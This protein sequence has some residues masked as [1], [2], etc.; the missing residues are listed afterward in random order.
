V[1]I[2]H[3]SRQNILILTISAAYLSAVT[4]GGAIAVHPAAM[5]HRQPSISTRKTPYA[6]PP[7]DVKAARKASLT[8]QSLRARA[9]T[10]QK[11][12]ARTGW[13]A[14]GGIERRHFWLTHPMDAFWRRHLFFAVRERI[15]WWHHRHLY[16]VWWL[17]Q[18]WEYRHRSTTQ[19]STRPSQVAFVEEFNGIRPSD[20]A[21]RVHALAVLNSLRVTSDQFGS[22]QSA[23]SQMSDAGDVVDAD[24][25]DNILLTSPGCLPTLS[26]LYK[27]SV[28]SNDDQIIDDRNRL[29]SLEDKYQVSVDPTIVVTDAARSHAREIFELLNPTQIA[30]Y[31]AD[32]AQAVPDITEILMAALDQCRQISDSDFNDYS[33][34][35]GQRV[36]V[37]TTGLDSDANQPVIDHVISML[38]RAR[39]LSDDEFAS[40]RQGFQHEAQ[41]IEKRCGPIDLINHA[42]QWDIASFLANPQAKG[43]TALRARQLQAPA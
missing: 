16:Y 13:I 15:F 31:V 24:V 37:L 11:K 1:K 12:W 38:T 27:D 8:Y 19:T 23:L 17:G 30:S 4:V 35:L 6:R 42:V 3:I 2:S 25:I 14:T 21:L 43:M 5:P 26:Q 32:R 22:F 18:G 36:A 29:L 20:I 40:Q 39:G 9:E 28:M 34:C 7:T 10:A 33:R 41:E